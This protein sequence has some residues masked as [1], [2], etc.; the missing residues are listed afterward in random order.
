MC[1]FF[2]SP[3]SE[4]SGSVS[5]YSGDMELLVSYIV[6][7]HSIKTYHAL[8]YIRSDVFLFYSPAHRLKNEVL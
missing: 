6:T 2:M 1:V 5:S 8:T 3:Q 7:L 4:V